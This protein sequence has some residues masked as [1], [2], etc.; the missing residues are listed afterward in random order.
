MYCMKLNGM[1]ECRVYTSTSDTYL[2]LCV[3][4]FGR[5]SLNIICLPDRMCWQTSAE[6]DLSRLDLSVVGLTEYTLWAMGEVQHW[7]L[8]HEKSVYFS[9]IQIYTACRTKIFR[10]TGIFLRYTQIV[11]AAK[12]M[13][14]MTVIGDFSVKLLSMKSRNH[15]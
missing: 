1:C 3:R 15:W 10:N 4:C 13:V 11:G 14:L 5:N 8:L 7:S 12:V 6:S 9:I 2:K